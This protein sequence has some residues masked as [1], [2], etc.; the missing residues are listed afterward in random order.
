M[1]MTSIEIPI[2]IGLQ[3]IG[4]RWGGLPMKQNFIEADFLMSFWGLNVN[5]ESS[6]HWGH[7]NDKNIEHFV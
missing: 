1:A 5:H 3:I 6:F 2:E 4:N 7:E